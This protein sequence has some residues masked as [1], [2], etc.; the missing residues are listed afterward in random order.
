VKNLIP[1]SIFLVAV[2]FVL[3][4]AIGFYANIFG[5]TFTNSLMFVGIILGLWAVITMKFNVNVLPD[6]RKGQKL[7]IN[8]PYKYIRHPMY[9]A[10]LITTL[11]WVLNR[12]DLITI[13]LWLI[14]FFDLIMKIKYEE[15]MLIKHFSEYKDYKKKVKA[16]IPFIW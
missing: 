7:F 6:I 2:Q 8:G 15:S 13:V 9:L 5:N 4:F 16:L 10:V 12:I 1:K 3:I 14:L 11:A